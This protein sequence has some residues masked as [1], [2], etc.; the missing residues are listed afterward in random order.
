MRQKGSNG[1]QREL[2]LIRSIHVASPQVHVRIRDIGKKPSPQ[3][4][5]GSV[6]RRASK[7]AHPRRPA[8]RRLPRTLVSSGGTFASSRGLLAVSIDF[9]QRVPF[10]VEDLRSVRRV[11]GG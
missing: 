2:G 9:D 1:R 4:E 3:C 7:E 10:R 5:N 6:Y 11:T 8:I